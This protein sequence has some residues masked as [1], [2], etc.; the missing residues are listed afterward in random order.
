MSRVYID[1][2]NSPRL[3]ENKV[4]KLEMGICEEILP[5]SVVKD[6]KRQ[7]G[8][9]HTDGYQKLSSL[10]MLSARQVLSAA[11]GVIAMQDKLQKNL[12]FPGEYILSADAIFT[13]ERLE[14]FKI[15]Y[16]P[17]EKERPEKSLACFVGSMKR[18]TSIGGAGYL[19]TLRILIET[20]TM[21]SE[22][23]IGAI[24]KMKQEIRICGIK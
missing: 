6:K 19:D 12:F 10:G 3:Y 4:Q 18:Y 14:K 17:V 15:A 20:G 21:R 1:L 16:I 2:K 24:E 8:V 5:L 13:D 22:E 9:Y 23:L 7:R 11:G